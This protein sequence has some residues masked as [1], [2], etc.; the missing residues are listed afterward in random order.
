MTEPSKIAPSR[1]RGRILLLLG[2]LLAISGVAAYVV[3]T[4]MQRLTA[5]WYMPALAIVGVAL[6]VISLWERRTVWRILALLIVL[7]LAG[8]E[9]AFLYAVRLP[10][11]SGP[12]AVGR[13]LPPFKTV[14]SDGKP[15]TERDIIGD[16]HNVLVFFRGRW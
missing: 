3:Q 16:Q 5:P 14:R 4:S 1:W 7:A 11:Y 13:T 6:V 12:I 9:G 8:L 10:T 2:V 15:F